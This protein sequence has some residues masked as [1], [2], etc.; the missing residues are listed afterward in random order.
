MPR[1]R[2]AS[3]KRRSSYTYVWGACGGFGH[4]ACNVSECR[5]RELALLKGPRCWLNKC[6]LWGAVE[7]VGEFTSR[8]ISCIVTQG[9]GWTILVAASFTTC[10]I[11]ADFCGG[12]TSADY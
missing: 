9:R 10:S 3:P 2:Q 4:T 5:H 8:L 12:R 6:A 1:D 7:R 11:F